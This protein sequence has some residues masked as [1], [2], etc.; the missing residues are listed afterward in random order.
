MP[1]QFWSVYYFTCSELHYLGNLVYFVMLGKF[2]DK[3]FCDCCYVSY[4][5]NQI[6]VEESSFFYNTRHLFLGECLCQVAGRRAGA[7]PGGIRNREP[8]ASLHQPARQV[9]VRPSKHI[10]LFS[11]PGSWVLF[12]SP[13]CWYYTPVQPADKLVLFSPP[14]S[15]V[16]F[17]PPGSWVLFSSPGSWYYTALQVAGY[18][19]ARQVAGCPPP[20]SILYC[21]ARLVA[22]YCSA[23]QVAGYCS[24]RQVAGYCSA[25]QIAGYCSARQ[26]AGYCSARQVAGYCSACF[27]ADLDIFA[28]LIKRGEHC[29]LVLVEG[30]DAYARMKSAFD[31]ENIPELVARVRQF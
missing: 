20:P 6:H 1:F 17:S 24:A 9:A 3:F 31:K 13:G 12:S 19:S 10:V 8:G 22:G 27:T 14:G 25:R 23:R 5:K 7:P 2:V 11:P 4:R 15:W 21:S 28:S 29:R 26:I 18:C 30:V 16:L